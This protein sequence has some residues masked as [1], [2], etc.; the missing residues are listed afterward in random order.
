M[1]K[2]IVASLFLMSCIFGFSQEQKKE[3]EKSITSVQ[4]GILGFWVN[5]ETRIAP[6]TALRSEIGLGVGFSYNFFS[7]NLSLAMFPTLRVE[8]KFYYNLERRIEKKKNIV[9]N[10]ANFISVPITYTPN[11][12]VISNIDNVKVIPII[13]IVPSYG[14]RRNIDNT[15][16]NYEFAFGIGYHH[17]FLKQV[18]YQKNEGKIAPNLTFRL[19]Y[20][21]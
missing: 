11:W 13:S 17:F 18:G 15:N 7:D 12:F 1:K 9:N 16:L 20:T 19:G 4:T 5:N 3:I 8:P 21:F 2:K 14:I 10:S 6:K